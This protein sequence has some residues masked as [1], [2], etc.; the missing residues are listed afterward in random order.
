MFQTETSGLARTDYEI[1]Q[2]NEIDDTNREIPK[3]PASRTDAA[4]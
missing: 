1:L 2:K 3:I 4:E